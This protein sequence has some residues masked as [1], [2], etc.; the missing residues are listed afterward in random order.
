MSGS[1]PALPASDPRDREALEPR[2]T[3]AEVKAR[4]LATTLS[5]EMV[6]EEF[7]ISPATV[8]NRAKA[9]RWPLERRRLW[10]HALAEGRKRFEADL[11]T[12]VA[13]YLTLEANDA[14]EHLQQLHEIRKKRGAQMS[15]MDHAALARA[16]EIESQRLRR[17]LGMRDSGTNGGAPEVRFLWVPPLVRPEI[18]REVTIDGGNPDPKPSEG[19]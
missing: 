18:P 14:M 10:R 11:E 15:M 16:C 6:A 5:L 13:A 12:R 17:A 7:G 1:V 9:E 3:W 2:P 19:G 4:Y 8:R